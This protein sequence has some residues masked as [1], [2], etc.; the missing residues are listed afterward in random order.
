[1]I[2]PSI[3]IS[4]D[5]MLSDVPPGPPAVLDHKGIDLRLESPAVRAI[6]DAVPVAEPS[7]APRIR[8]E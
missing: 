6:F 5:D 2:F 4:E 3:P 1:M 8:E 7:G